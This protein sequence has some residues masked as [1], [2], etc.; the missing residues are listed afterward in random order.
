MAERRGF[1]EAVAL[2]PEKLA[3]I[4]SG[5]RPPASPP[6]A[7]AAA[8]IPGTLESGTAPELETEQPPPS[9]SVRPKRPRAPREAFVSRTQAPQVAAEEGGFYGQILVPLTTRLQPRTADAL[10][11]ACLEQKLARKSP[12]SQQE[13]VELAVTQWLAEN[14]FL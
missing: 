12:H 6:A 7:V 5:G 3:F 9:P 11:R 8:A 4:Q 1:G 2:T 10:R 13:I 14:G